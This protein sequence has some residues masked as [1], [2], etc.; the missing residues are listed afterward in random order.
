MAIIVE[1]EK[2]GI[3]LM[4]VLITIGIILALFGAT[5]YLFFAEVPG[6]EV[7]ST[8][9]ARQA[10]QISNIKFDTSITNSPVYALLR[11]HVGPP[12]QGSFGRENPF[13]PFIVLQG[14]PT[15]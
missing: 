2:K 4:P 11:P 1:K 8:P 7:L 6:I 12:A 15:Q 3:G 5:W 14:T 13:L 10:T 9:E